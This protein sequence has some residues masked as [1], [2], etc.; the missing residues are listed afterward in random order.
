MIRAEHLHPDRQFQLWF[1]TTKKKETW[2]RKRLQG[3]PLE[4]KNRLQDNYNKHP[5]GMWGRLAS[6]DFVED[7]DRTCPNENCIVL[8]IQ[9]DMEFFKGLLC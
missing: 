6:M 4:L 2:D 7:I 5:N 1:F 8:Y 9:T 3:K